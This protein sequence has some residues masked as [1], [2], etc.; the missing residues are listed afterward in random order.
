MAPKSVFGPVKAIGWA[1]LG[2]RG[3]VARERDSVQVSPLAW[4]GAGI[5]AVVALV[6][7]LMVLVHWLVPTV[8]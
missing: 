8:G 4:I 3:G 1:F 2:I 6:I 5:A 7:V